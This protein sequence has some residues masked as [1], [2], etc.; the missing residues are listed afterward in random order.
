MAVALLLPT[1]HLPARPVGPRLLNLP[2]GTHIDF[3]PSVIIMDN[4]PSKGSC[5]SRDTAT[6]LTLLSHTKP[7]NTQKHAH[8]YLRAVSI[9]KKNYGSEKSAYTSTITGTSDP[10][11]F[12][13][14][15]HRVG[16][17]TR[18]TR[19]YSSYSIARPRAFRDLTKIKISSPT[20]SFHIILQNRTDH[21]QIKGN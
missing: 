3:A 5:R 1:M 16:K 9:H 15:C 17:E 20:F 12:V 4:Q 18:T 7:P 21:R 14:S 8:N 13:P 6:S 10:P 2:R 19:V 11:N